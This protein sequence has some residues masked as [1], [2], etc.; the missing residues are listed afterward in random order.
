MGLGFPIKEIEQ[1][2]HPLVIPQFYD[3]ADQTIERAAPYGDILADLQ[4]GG[5]LAHDAITL[6]R[7]QAIDK[8]AT[9]QTWPVAGPHQRFYAICSKDRSPGPALRPIFDKNVAG[10]KR[11]RRVKHA[12]SVPDAFRNHRAVDMEIL[13]DEVL[14][15]IC[16]AVRDGIYNKPF[17]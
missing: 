15:G 5:R 9:K 3:L 14:T 16:L 10:K 6:S 1:D 7:L 13:S 4:R 2:K 17:F 11:S 12:P 8:A